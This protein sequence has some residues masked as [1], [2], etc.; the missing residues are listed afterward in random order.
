[1]FNLLR[2]KKGKARIAEKRSRVRAIASKRRRSSLSDRELD[3]LEED[4][5]DIILAAGFIND[6]YFSQMG[7]TPDIAEDVGA[8]VAS[9]ESMV[10]DEAFEAATAAREEYQERTPVYTPDPTPVASSDDDTPRYSGGSSS[11]ES[12]SSGSSDSGSSDSGSSDD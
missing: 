1:M 9:E 6:I 4:A 10:R 11:S 12:Y 8:N 2:G 5:L 3:F 7:V